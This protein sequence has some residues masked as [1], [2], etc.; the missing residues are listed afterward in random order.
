MARSRLRGT[1]GGVALGQRLLGKRNVSRL[2][3]P[4]RNIKYPEQEQVVALSADSPI[5]ELAI[6]RRAINALLKGL[7][8]DGPRRHVNTIEELLELSEKDLLSYRNIG[9]RTVCDIQEE[10]ARVLPLETYSRRSI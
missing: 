9:R 7:R 4:S 2:D 8:M 1:C 10:L 3:S 6:S 5:T